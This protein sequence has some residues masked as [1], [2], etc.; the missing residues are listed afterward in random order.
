M[1]LQRYSHKAV[2]VADLGVVTQ[3][4]ERVT[5]HYLDDHINEIGYLADQWKI[6]EHAIPATRTLVL[7]D[8]LRNPAHVELMCGWMDELAV[9]IYR[10]FPDEKKDLLVI[11][12]YDFNE[13]HQLAKLI[14]SANVCLCTLSLRDISHK[15]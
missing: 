1:N 3:T 15:S 13:E 12:H 5:L 8:V 6:E 14:A 7:V 9:P 2:R 11:F 4:E 10:Y